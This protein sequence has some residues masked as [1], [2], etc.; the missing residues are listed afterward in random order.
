MT[1]TH[2]SDA[3]MGKVERRHRELA[4]YALRD[5]TANLER[6]E[7]WVAGVEPLHDNWL[8]QRLAQVIANNEH[9]LLHRIAELENM[10]L[11]EF[12][13]FAIKRAMVK[14]K[15]VMRAAKALGIGRATLYRRLVQ[16]GQQFPV[17][18]YDGQRPA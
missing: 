6:L 1:Q 2:T 4:A 3:L 17:K 18:Y 13:R 5:N 11:P 7:A 16:F 10:T 9:P 8:P 12:E 14:F 15:S